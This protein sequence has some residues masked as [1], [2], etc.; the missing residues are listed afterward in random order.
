[1]GHIDVEKVKTAVQ[2]VCKDK[3]REYAEECSKQ[4]IAY[5]KYEYVIAQMELA[6][7]WKDHGYDFKFLPEQFLHD[8]RTEITEGDGLNLSVKVTFPQENFRGESDDK[9]DFFRTY[10]V[11]NAAQKMKFTKR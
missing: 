9:I 8:I 3:V 7:S 2:D 4:M 5:I 6:G 11:D 1:M 10:V